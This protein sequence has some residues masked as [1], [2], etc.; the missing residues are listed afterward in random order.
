[1][2][3]SRRSKLMSFNFCTLLLFVFLVFSSQVKAIGNVVDAESGTNGG[4]YG[5]N[6]IITSDGQASAAGLYT[7]DWK[8]TVSDAIDV[9]SVGTN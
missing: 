5:Y 9:T 2:S 6:Q 3:L 4:T 7:W 1:M 8:P